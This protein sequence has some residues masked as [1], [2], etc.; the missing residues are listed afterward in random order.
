[1]TDFPIEIPDSARAVK[2]NYLEK[3]N[4][5]LV[6]EIRDFIKATGTPQLWHGHTHTRPPDGS[7]IVYCGEFD[8]PDSHHGETKR[9][10]WAPCPACHADS[11]W[12]YKD[13]RIAW[14]PEEK[15]IRNIGGNCFAKI[16]KEG[17][18]AALAEY[19]LEEHKRR[20]REFLLLKAPLVPGAMKVIERAIAVAMDVDIV[21]MVLSRRLPERI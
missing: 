16:N 21:R 7:L 9:H 10:L 6:R 15:V 2:A 14:F 20:N 18:K 12:Y 11:A 19:E 3:P 13:G 17:H 8:L 5:K 1:M 4:P